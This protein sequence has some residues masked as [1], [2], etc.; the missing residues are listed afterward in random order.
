M[1]ARNSL[2]IITRTAI[3]LALTIV[4][5]T[6]GRSIPLGQFNQFITGSLVNACLIVAAD[7]TGLW[8]GAAVAIL[9]PFGAILTGATMP[10]PF[11]PVVAAGNFILVLMYA[12]IR[13][14]HILGIAAGAVLKFAFLFAGV[15]IFVRL[16]NMPG[17]KAAAMT[18]MFS[19]P[20]L[21]TAAIG[22]IIAL[23]VLK[24]LNRAW[25]KQKQ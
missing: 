16:M 3:L 24:A 21:V 11:A 1:S 2:R 6:M 8:G 19:W 7:T 23:L 10:L 18:S 20:Q 17:Q 25:E 13:R 22:G 14:N 15:N 4:F 5:Q 9:A 12:L